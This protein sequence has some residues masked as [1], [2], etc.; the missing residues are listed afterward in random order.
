MALGHVVIHERVTGL[1]A[2]PG[3]EPAECA[4]PA[5]DDGGGDGIH[6][7]RQAEDH[8]G[9]AEELQRAWTQAESCC[10]PGETPVPGHGGE[11][12]HAT[13]VRGL[14]YLFLLFSCDGFSSFHRC[15]N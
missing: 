7:G 13:R 4:R 5:E 3:A 1:P 12:A 8:G 10:G 14:S 9:E 11:G 15:D 6:D 2:S